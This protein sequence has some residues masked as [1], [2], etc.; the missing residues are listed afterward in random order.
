MKSLHSLRLKTGG[1][2]PPLRQPP[3]S[4]PHVWAGLPDGLLL[5][6]LARVAPFL[7]FRLR[8]VFRR[9][10]AILHD[11]TFLAAHA[12]VPCLLTFSRDRGAAH[13]PQCSVLSLPF[14]PATSYPIDTVS[15][16]YY[17]NYYKMNTITLLSLKNGQLY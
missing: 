10:A 15:M 5:E 4:C 6:V 3:Q 1:G 13:S 11:P 16:T 12:T 9:W 2:G 7:L 8:R 17:I 14:A